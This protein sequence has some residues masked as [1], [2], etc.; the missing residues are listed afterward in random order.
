MPVDVACGVVRL[1][2]RALERQYEDSFGRN[3]RKDVSGDV[4]GFE[5]T[6]LEAHLSGDMVLGTLLMLLYIFQTR[7]VFFPDRRLIATPKHIGLDYDDVFF[8]TEDGVRLHGWFVPVEGAKDVLL[9]FHGNA[10]NISHR[11]DSIRIFC[12]RR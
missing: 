1:A 8:K 7:L 4:S 5:E 3:F 9:F 12:D 11:L 2:I 6:R 10:G